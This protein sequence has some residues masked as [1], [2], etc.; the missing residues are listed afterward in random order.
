MS[1]ARARDTHVIGKRI[2]RFDVK[3]KILGKE[4][5]GGDLYLPDML[6]GYPIHSPAPHAHLRK[7]DVEAARK[8]PGVHAVLTAADIPG[9]NVSSPYVVDEQPF[10][11]ADRI[12]SV[13]DVICVIAA[14]NEEIA[15]RA[16]GLVSV[17]FDPLPV[18]SS[19]QEAMKPEAYAIHLN[20]NIAKH[21][22][23]R[24]GDIEVGF[25][26]ADVV[27]EGT[28][29]TPFIEHSYLEPD[30]AL[31]YFDEDETLIVKVGSQGIN[32]ERHNIANGL[33][34][35]PDSV[36][37]IQPPMGG[38][39]GGKE[40][41]TVGFLAALLAYHTHRPVKMVWSRQQVVTLSNKRHPSSTYLKTGA[42][43]DGRLTALK[44]KI[45]FDTGAYAHWGPS[46]LSFASC[47]VAGPYVVPH[48]W[49]DGYAVYTN[50]LRAGSMRGWGIPQVAFAWES[51]MDRLAVALGIHPLVFRWMNAVHEGSTAITGGSLPPG[52]GLRETIQVAAKL[53]GIQL[54]AST[55]GP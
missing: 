8:L 35:P 41:T 5:F 6:T 46:V 4:R 21:A 50:N 31:V 26:Q 22:K 19:P 48:V 2:P 3:D 23:I 34:L 28:Y 20:G 38:A 1:H 14:D 37:V 53:R 18:I 54:P 44:A 30:A 49:V 43:N 7:I 15:R 45:V 11:A 25:A 9:K 13:G 32:D 40:E 33:G 51:Q 52:V 12:R 36:R 55:N 39:F 42:T 24:H 16:A 17:D 27:V 29:T 47:M 10:M